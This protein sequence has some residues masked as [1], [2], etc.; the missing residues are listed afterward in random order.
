ML[1]PSD[2]S[3]AGFEVKYE[4][5]PEVVFHRHIYWNTKHTKWIGLLGLNYKTLL[6]EDRTKRR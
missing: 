3:C 4:M 5:Y 2:I 6:Y 1:A